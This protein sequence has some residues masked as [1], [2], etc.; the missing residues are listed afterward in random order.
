MFAFFHKK[1]E[2]QPRRDWPWTLNI[3]GYPRSNPSW[4]DIRAGLEALV[5]DSGS[6]LILEQRDPA[7]PKGRYWFI[8]C[9][10]ALEGPDA[11]QYSLEIGF[12]RDGKGHLLDRTL[13]RLEQVIAYFDWAFRWKPLDFAGFEDMSDMVQ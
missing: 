3:G 1:D 5:Q 9:A 13:P 10:I 12:R 11:G 4:E 2:S 7:G 8:Q 6:F